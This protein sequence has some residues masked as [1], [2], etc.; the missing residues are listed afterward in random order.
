MTVLLRINPKN[1][2]CTI[3]YIS[4]SK[5]LFLN[6]KL[7]FGFVPNISNILTSFKSRDVKRFI[8]PSIFHFRNTILSVARRIFI[9]N[10]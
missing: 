4:V 6:F 1:Y 7:D 5:L 2:D 3:F 9:L 10:S 8:Y